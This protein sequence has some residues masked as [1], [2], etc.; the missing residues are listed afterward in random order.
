VGLFKR[1]DAPALGAASASFAFIGLLLAFA[2][3]IVTATKDNNG[4]TVVASGGVSVTLSEFKLTPDT[5][6]VSS[7]GSITVTN[8]GTTAHNLTID[9]TSI[10][11][12]DLNPGESAI[13]QLEGLKDG[14]Y[15]MICS[16]PGH[17][18]AGMKGTLTVGAGGAGGAAAQSGTA[19]GTADQLRASN[20]KDDLTQKKPVDA[21][22]GQLAAILDNAKQTGKIDP[23]LY[24]PNTSYGKE[25]G[26]LGGNPLLGPPV[27]KPTVLADG[28]KQ[29]QI[30]AKVVQWEIE[31]KKFVSAWTYDGM[32]P[33]PTIHVSPGD[34]VS[35]VLKNELPQST[36]IHFHGIDV[37]V[38][39]DGVPWV[40]QDPVKPG[41]TFDYRFTA[42]L[43]PAVGM[44]HS[45]HH[46]EHQVPD[47]L[48]G[49]FIVGNV[50]LPAGY[51][52]AAQFPAPN[53][54]YVMVLNDAGSIGLSL[55]GKSFPATAPVVTPVGKWIQ[56]DYMNE[57]LQ[58]HPMHLHGPKQ[59]V[60]AEDGNPVPVP[61]YVDTLMVAPGQR[62]TVLVKPD[63]TFLDQ[64]SKPYVPALG[65]G[66][67]AFHC[68]ILSHAERNDGMFGMVTTFVVLPPG[69][70]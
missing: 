15:T 45:H 59:L 26:T 58:I 50:A 53:T 64:S 19:G 68:H 16:V 39:M 57:G 60:I 47:G 69:T 10:H 22:V 31:P 51:D 41:Q 56:I 7:G 14:T 48:M 11:T 36:A 67:W 30:T 34:K 21:Y 70:I 3:L 8:A 44:Y 1:S 37:P 27:L 33:G 20:T 40:T 55:N 32:V 63:A 49:A 29:F 18:A 66:V 43:T 42:Q 17:A 65:A 25:F 38:S 2:A 24:K 13:L 52:T 61:Y 35:I 12:K 5:V 6:T 9:G 23:A 4:G 46:G 54:P 62:F 28:T